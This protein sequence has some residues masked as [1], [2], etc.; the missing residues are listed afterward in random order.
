MN[1]IGPGKGA[2]SGTGTTVVTQNRRQIG[3]LFGFLVLAFAVALARGVAGA[4]TTSAHV[5]AAVFGGVLVVAFVAGW[6][7]MIQRPARL[8]ITEDA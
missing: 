1:G 3:L 8:E 6:I 2:D 7:V 4:Q 5:A